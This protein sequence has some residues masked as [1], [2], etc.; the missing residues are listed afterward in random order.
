MS[1]PAA[2]IDSAAWSSPWR[3]VRVRDKAGLVVILL[4][5]ALLAPPFPAAPIVL[6][7]VTVIALVWAKVPA[8][9]WFIAVTAQASFLLLSGAGLALEV[10]WAPFR[11]WVTQ[12]GLWYAAGIM[13]RALAAGSATILLAFTTPMV[14][15]LMALRRIGVPQAVVDVAAVAYRMTFALAD[16]A[17]SIRAA[18]QARLGLTTWRS[19]ISSAADI[20]ATILLRAWQHAARLEAGLAGRGDGALTVYSEPRRCYRLLVLVATLVAAIVVGICWWFAGQEYVLPTTKAVALG[21]STADQV[22][23]QNYIKI[24]PHT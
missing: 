16:S 3:D 4:G 21:A 23:S 13:L 18:Q 24:G 20:M 1:K 22:L 14:E 6:V 5:C 11:I 15:V 7:A 8:R 9:L 10:S 17:R 19:Q 2:S 12:G